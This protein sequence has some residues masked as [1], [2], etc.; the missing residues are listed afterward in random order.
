MSAPQARAAL[1]VAQQLA[2]DTEAAAFKQ[3]EHPGQPPASQQQPNDID[4]DAIVDKAFREV[5]SRL[6][7]ER[8]RRGFT[9]W[10]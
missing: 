7:I 5:L 4:I 9:R 2:A 3:T 1:P 8:E 10:A 6:S